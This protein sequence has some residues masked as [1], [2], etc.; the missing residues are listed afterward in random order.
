[1]LQHKSNAMRALSIAITAMMVFVSI[2]AS[3][4]CV[5]AATRLKVTAS[6][7]TIFV[8]Q[9][10]KLKANK[11][12]KWSVSNRKIAK[13][14]NIKKRTVTVKGLKAGTV[15]VK[16]KYGKTIRKIKI[17][18]KKGPQ[19]I[20]LL[21]TRDEIGVGEYCTVFVNSVVPSAAS[22][23]VTFKSSDE[24]VAI[25]E[26]SGLVTGISKG[27]VTITA[28]SKVNK[29]TKAQVKIKV[30][31][32]KAGKITLDVYLTDEE[33]YP[34]GKVAR[35]WLPVPKDDSNQ[36]ITREKI[37]YD[38]DDENTK[39]AFVTDSAG[40]KQA[41]IEWSENVD[42]KDRHATL[43]YDLYRKAVVR[44]DS[45]ASME[46][47]VVDRTR[48]AEYLKETYWS[49]DLKSGIVKNTADDIVSAA[50]AETV[51][52]QAHA[53]YDFMCDNMIRTDDKTV[54]F[55]DVV[56]ILKGF[57]GEEGGR[58]AGS[59]MD[60]NSVFVALCRA[61][62]IPARTLYGF[63]FTTLGPNCRAEFYLPGYGWVPV[64]PAL[65]IKQG[66]GLDAPPKTDHDIT[67]EGIKD[68]YWGNAEENW[69]CVNM[70]RDIWL[71]PPQSVD[72]GGE[73]KEVL[74]PDGSINL[75]MF[76]YGEFDG[77]YIPCQ[78]SKNFK[79]QYSFEEDDPLGCGC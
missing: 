24:S 37:E 15:Y 38:S 21:A 7:K 22:H 13:L 14:T 41:Y 61:E 28:T 67:W 73:Y 66:R 36:K 25:V 11:N 43:S 60:M 34:A 68:K 5:S 1:M 64:D 49:G 63:R 46:K 45:I 4:E 75:F 56:S 48:F 77:E 72:T 19:K 62:D 10:S 74:N 6:K 57:K 26:D 53:I 27:S 30:V 42:P 78:N 65:A 9:T 50:G 3:T 32:A 20:N 70:G 59:C 12:V 69:I 76:P 51:Y 2:I 54:I 31:P 52:E 16:A 23:S 40:G 18:I 55:G 79:Y 39:A 17:V 44:K 33:R 71:D 58:N 8:T 29:T 47:G 35:V